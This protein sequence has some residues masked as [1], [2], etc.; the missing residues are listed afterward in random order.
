MAVDFSNY[1]AKPVEE[2]ER[3][4]PPPVG[5]YIGTI[6][7]WTPRERNFGEGREKTPVIELTI[8]NLIPCDD[9]LENDADPDVVRNKIVTKDYDLSDPQGQYGL[10]RIGEEALELDCKGLSLGDLLPLFIDGQVK[11]HHD[12]RM[13]T[14][15]NEGVAFSKVGKIMKAD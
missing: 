12:H 15:D 7:K 13:G 8:T 9:A 10:R 4:S 5:H 6:K 14:G 3:P 2:I 1:L 11:L